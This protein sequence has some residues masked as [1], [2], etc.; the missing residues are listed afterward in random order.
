MSPSTE[1]PVDSSTSDHIWDQATFVMNQWTPRRGSKPSE[2]TGQI[3][4]LPPEPSLFDNLCRVFITPAV[5]KVGEVLLSGFTKVMLIIGGLVQW[6]VVVLLV[7]AAAYWGGQV[8]YLRAIRMAR[9]WSCQNL[10]PSI[11]TT[12]ALNCS[13]AT[14]D[15]PGRVTLGDAWPTSI[16]S[17][18]KANPHAIDH[19]ATSASYTATADIQQALSRAVAADSV[20][21]EIALVDELAGHLYSRLLASGLEDMKGLASVVEEVDS[22][23]R[24]VG[25]AVKETAFTL[26]T[27]LTSVRV[28]ATLALDELHAVALVDSLQEQRK[29]LE[30]LLEILQV[31]L[32]TLRSQDRPMRHV[33][34]SLAAHDEMLHFKLFRL[35][36]HPWM[37][38]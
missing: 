1:E 30:K 23:V 16:F 7:V 6:L 35:L 4:A 3:R 24:R 22:A 27:L 28:T 18:M 2:A 33:Q 32:A 31:A 25:C 19:V 11:T 5:S 10:P 17:G 15:D 36:G 20:S 34:L 8:V 38:I 21:R 9:D 37:N 12:L 26:H 13:S 29:Q 14:L